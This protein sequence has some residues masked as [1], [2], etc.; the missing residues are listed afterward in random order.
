MNFFLHTKK[1]KN[2]LRKENSKK[3]STDD[4]QFKDVW[5]HIK[6]LYSRKKK[7]E[8]KVLSLLGVLPTPRRY[9]TVGLLGRSLSIII[10]LES[11][12]LFLRLL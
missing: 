3:R 1:K 4:V 8:G 7:R 12:P 5:R 11:C 10:K 2:V 9:P 6:S